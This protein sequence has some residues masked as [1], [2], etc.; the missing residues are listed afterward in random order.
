[1]HAHAPLDASRQRAGLV[2]REIMFAAL[3]QHSEDCGQRL[4]VAL[5]NARFDVHRLVGRIQM[6]HDDECQAARRRR[7]G[8]KLLQRFEPTESRQ[9]LTGI[10]TVTR[11]ERALA[12][13]VG[14]D[15]AKT[16]AFRTIQRI[17]ALNQDFGGV[18]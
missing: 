7:V 14:D 17:S 5:H 6:L 15:K 10:V 1:M 9:K 2:M 12:A 16:T 3:A 4:L 13:I 11:Q 18:A 8:E